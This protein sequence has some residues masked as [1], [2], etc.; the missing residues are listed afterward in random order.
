MTRAVL[1]QRYAGG[2]KAPAFFYLPSS[3]ACMDAAV[4]SSALFDTSYVL[5]ANETIK[6]TL[7][8]VRNPTVNLRNE[9][10]ELIE[11]SIPCEI[12]SHTA[13]GR[14]SQG[15]AYKTDCPRIYAVKIMAY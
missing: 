10:V 9:P 13:R 12:A 15:I 6:L 14:I 1:V 7:M 11:K 5:T 4:C 2:P 8:N 3:I